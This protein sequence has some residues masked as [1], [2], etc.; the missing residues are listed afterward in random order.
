MAKRI[1]LKWLQILMV[2]LLLLCSPAALAEVSKGDAVYVKA[3][4]GSFRLPIATVDEFLNVSFPG[5]PVIELMGE[6]KESAI[7]KV[8]DELGKHFDVEDVEYFSF[9]EHLRHFNF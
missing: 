7:N 2:F 9:K 4:G 5:F 8:K 3:A 1:V 6:N